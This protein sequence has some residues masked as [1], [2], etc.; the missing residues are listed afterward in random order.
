MATLSELEHEIN[1][2]KARNRRVEADKAWEL[3]RTR[4]TFIS[5]TTFVLLY[6]FFTLNHSEAPFL[7]ALISILA[8]LLSTF[9]YGI[10]K[11]WWLKKRSV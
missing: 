6:V 7:N 4:T 5:L 9:T 2:I 1:E 3:S 11:G 10:L 8:Y